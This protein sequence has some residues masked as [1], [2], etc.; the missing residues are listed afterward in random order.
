M[1]VLWVLSGGGGD[2]PQHRL[3]T[4]EHLS[5]VVQCANGTKQLRD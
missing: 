5:Y 4:A 2:P 1:Q 3:W